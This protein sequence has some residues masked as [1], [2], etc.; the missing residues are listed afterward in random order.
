METFSDKRRHFRDDH[1]FKE[2]DCL[3]I[4]LT[5]LLQLLK[6]PLVIKTF[7]LLH[8]LLVLNCRLIFTK[9][10]FSLIMDKIAQN[11]KT[12]TLL[13]SFLFKKLGNNCNAGPNI[14]YLRIPLLYLILHVYHGPVDLLQLGHKLPPLV[15]QVRI[16]LLQLLS[17]LA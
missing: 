8:G 13:Y 1:T 17:L 4:I 6:L 7:L 16:I 9:Q 3:N 12:I 10:T 14:L 15:H 5:F 2:G 11:L